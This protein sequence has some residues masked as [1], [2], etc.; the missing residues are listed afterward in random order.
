M[1]PEGKPARRQARVG[2][3]VLAKCVGD[4]KD[5]RLLPGETRTKLL[6]W[7]IWSGQNVRISAKV[8]EARYIRATAMASGPRLPTGL[9]RR[10]AAQPPGEVSSLSSFC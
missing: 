6:D 10:Q 8:L 3:R 9:P 7:S 2:P 5:K 1:G 4:C